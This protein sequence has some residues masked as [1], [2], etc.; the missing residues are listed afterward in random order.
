MPTSGTE[1]GSALALDGA[2]LPHISYYD[3]LDRDLRYTFYFVADYACYLPVV[4]KPTSGTGDGLG[5]R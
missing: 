2:G 3:G 5:V 4:S 1:G